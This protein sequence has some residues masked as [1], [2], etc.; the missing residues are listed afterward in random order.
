MSQ[1]ALMSVYTPFGC[2][3]SQTFL[4]FDDLDS[5]EEHLPGIV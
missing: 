1:L 3:S 4:I 2:D 5:V